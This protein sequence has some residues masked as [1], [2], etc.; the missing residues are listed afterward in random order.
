MKSSM[1]RP[2]RGRAREKW[3]LKPGPHEFRAVNQVGMHA[4]GADFGENKREPRANHGTGLTK[5]QEDFLVENGI[6]TR[7]SLAETKAAIGRGELAESE[8]RTRQEG[9]DASETAT[10]VATRLHIALHEVDVWRERGDLFAFVADG[11][12]HYPTWQF[13]DAIDR[14]V[15]P[16]LAK[17]TAALPDDMHPAG[18]LGFFSTPQRGAGMNGQPMTP[19][20]WLIRGGDVQT[21]TDILDSFLMS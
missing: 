9:I 15:L 12:L 6:F 2:P 16:H 21:L 11:T 20:Q 7:E 4:H 14:P 18:I 5:E 8:R 3:H 17:L 10:Q 19:G 1:I 13:T